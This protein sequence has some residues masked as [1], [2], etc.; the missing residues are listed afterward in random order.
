M[1][2]KFNFYCDPGHG[3]IKVPLTLLSELGIAD[4]ISSYSYINKDHAFLEEDC[5]ASL[6]IHSM[7]AQG[8]KISL[9][10]FHTNNSSKIRSYDEYKNGK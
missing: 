10:E 3:W 8:Y 6:F 1:Q 5:D 4:K 9:N 7:K 2:T